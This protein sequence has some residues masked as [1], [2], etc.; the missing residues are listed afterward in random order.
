MYVC[1]PVH[2]CLTFG[3]DTKIHQHYRSLKQEIRGRVYE[4]GWVRGL[5]NGEGT[6]HTGT[7]QAY[8]GFFEG[9]LY[10]GQGVLRGPDQQVLEGEWKRGK[11]NGETVATSD[12]GDG[13]DKTD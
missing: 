7:G 4:G 6:L 13:G 8:Q 3:K 12:M 2:T 11:L 9:D 5:K 10:H 1:A